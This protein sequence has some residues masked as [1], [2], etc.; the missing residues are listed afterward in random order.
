[1][2]FETTQV[3]HFEHNEEDYYDPTRL[4]TITRPDE[5]RTKKRKIPLGT[6]RYPTNK[7]N[8]KRTNVCLSFNPVVSDQI[9][10]L[11]PLSA[12]A[13]PLHRHQNRIIFDFDP[14]ALRLVMREPL[15]AR[16]PNGLIK[17]DF[18]N[19]TTPTADVTPQPTP[20][21]TNKRLRNVPNPNAPRKRALRSN[22]RT[23]EASQGGSNDNQPDVNQAEIKQALNQ[24]NVRNEKDMTD[25]KDGTDSQKS[26]EESDEDNNT[27]PCL[28]CRQAELAP[29]RQPP[30]QFFG[31]GFRHHQIPT[32][33]TG[34]MLRSFNL[35]AGRGELNEDHLVIGR[36][37]CPV[38]ERDDQFMAMMVSV[39]TR[40]EMVALQKHGGTG[41]TALGETSQLRVNTINEA[42]CTLIGVANHPQRE[43]SGLHSNSRLRGRS[44]HSPT[45]ILLTHI[46][47]PNQ[48]DTLSKS[49]VPL[50]ETVIVKNAS[51]VRRHVFV[52]HILSWSCFDQIDGTKTFEEL[53]NIGNC[54]LPSDERVQHTMGTLLET[55]G[56]D[57]Q[58]DKAAHKLPK[59]GSV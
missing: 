44:R 50:L 54:A 59:D 9:H 58:N 14:F 40:Q 5:K 35:L 18:H 52:M 55:F 51:A 21:P 11:P 25:D 57:V 30:N 4:D 16:V 29:A 26:G 23:S 6:K 46:H 41:S 45:F 10:S 39:F 31:S 12:I 32:H 38:I 53:K 2:C 48:V 49:N 15:R 1:M 36:Q 34:S 33:M 3:Q 47:L 37:M 27:T 17:F 43:S 19:V 28:A 20:A 56:T 42:M 7:T 24:F 8:L 22:S 13:T